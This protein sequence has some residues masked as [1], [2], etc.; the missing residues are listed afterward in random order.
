MAEGMT[1]EK[2]C[3]LAGGLVTDGLAGV[4]DGL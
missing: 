1:V 3:R 2:G 4:A